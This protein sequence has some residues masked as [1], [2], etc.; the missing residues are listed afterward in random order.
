MASR[1]QK[2]HGPAISELL[3][4]IQLPKKLAIVKCRAHKTDETVVIKGNTAADE[5]AKKTAIG[6]GHMITLM[7]VEEL[8]SGQAEEMFVYA[9]NEAQA[10]AKP[11]EIA[12][13]KSKELFRI[14]KCGEGEQ[15]CG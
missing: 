7:R 13:K 1:E 12:I 9:I 4:T 5:A 3:G 11:K 2:G 15:A 8:E 14:C 6:K 10:A